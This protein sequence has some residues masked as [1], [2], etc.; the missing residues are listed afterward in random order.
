MKKFGGSRKRFRSSSDW[1]Q[2]IQTEAEKLKRSAAVECL[3]SASEQV[4][5]QLFYFIMEMVYD[6]M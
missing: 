2:Y 1:W 6:H 3:M 5:E 4:N